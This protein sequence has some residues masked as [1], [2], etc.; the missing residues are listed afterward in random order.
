MI[1]GAVSV[2]ISLVVYAKICREKERMQ[3]DDNTAYSYLVTAG[4]AAIVLLLIYMLGSVLVFVWGI[5]AP[6]A[7]KD[8]IQYS[9]P[10]FHFL[11][12]AMLLNS[13]VLL[14]SK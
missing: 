13:T 3:W 4:V 10:I 6:I 12:P 2:A 14:Y 1:I 9:E 8:Y 11:F 7:G 5:A